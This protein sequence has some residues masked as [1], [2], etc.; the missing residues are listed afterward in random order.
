MPSGSWS[1]WAKSRRRARRAGSPASA[2]G[3]PTFPEVVGDVSTPGHA[4]SRWVHLV[5]M[6]SRIVS[7]ASCPLRSSSRGPDSHGP[8]RTGRTTTMICARQL[9]GDNTVLPHYESHTVNLTRQCYY[10]TG[11]IRYTAGRTSSI[12]KCS[13]RYTASFHLRLHS[14]LAS[15]T[16]GCIKVGGLDLFKALLRMAAVADASVEARHLSRLS[17]ASTHVE[18]QCTT[19]SR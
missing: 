14:C 1:S 11:G 17:A 13:I 19:K 2:I 3:D 6:L 12:L 4:V 5:R 15:I 10:Y 9:F 8:R 18:E 7:A 16:G